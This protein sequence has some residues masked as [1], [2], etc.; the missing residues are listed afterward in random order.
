MFILCA[1]S[2]LNNSNIIYMPCT[3]L[4][5]LFVIFLFSF[6]IHIFYLWLKAPECWQV[7]TS[8]K[9]SSSTLQGALDRSIKIEPGTINKTGCTNFDSVTFLGPNDKK[10]TTLTTTLI[11]NSCYFYNP[12]SFYQFQWEVIWCMS[13]CSSR[14]LTLVCSI[15]ADLNWKVPLTQCSSSAL[16][17]LH[18]V[19][20]IHFKDSSVN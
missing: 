9:V 2:I 20:Q 10:N 12:P 11:S 1:F 7:V 6:Y 17:T 5:Q 16:V 14:F 15:G 4:Q 13:C 3:V 19:S 8:S 18:S